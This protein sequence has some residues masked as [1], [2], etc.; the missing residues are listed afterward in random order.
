MDRNEGQSS[1][2]IWTILQGQHG[3]SFELLK[4]AWS[5]IVVVL[6]L[7]VAVVLF[8][9][10]PFNAGRWLSAPFPGFFTGP[11]LVITLVSQPE[12]NGDILGWQVTAVDG[13]ALSNS[14]DLT[15]ALQSHA[16][17]QSVQF[18]LRS[19]SGDLSTQ[20]VSLQT[21]PGMYRFTDLYFPYFVGLIYFLTALWIFILRG[22]SLSGQV[23]TLFASSVAIVTAGL[24]DVFTTQQWIYLWS[25]SLALASGT[26]LHFGLLFPRRSRLLARLPVL[27]VAPYL[28]AALL[29]PVAW[30]SLTAPASSTEFLRSWRAE[31]LFA[32]LSVLLFLALLFC[33]RSRS[34]SPVE[35]ERGLMVLLGALVSFGPVAF[36]FLAATFQPGTGYS[37]YL[38]LSLAI[39]PLITGYS[40]QRQRQLRTD[41]IISRTLL[42]AAMTVLAG[43]GYALLVS[44]LGIILIKSSLDSSA[45]IS[46]V[47]I[48]SLALLLNPLRLRAQNLVDAVFFRGEQALQDRIRTFGHALTN[49]VDLPEIVATLR[50]YIQ[51]ALIPTRLHVFI[52]DPL[53][54][55]YI[56]SLDEGGRASSEIRFSVQS[57]LIQALSQLQG[58]LFLGSRDDIPA[59]LYPD[60]PRLALLAAHV[61]LPLPGQKRLA[62]F[63]ALGGRQSGESYTSRDLTH[64]EALCDQAA[65]A[66]ERAQVVANMEHRVREMNVLSRVAQGV[67]VTLTFD[68]ILELIYAQTNQ[69]LPTR[70]FRLT[71]VD[72]V[73]G[74]FRHAFYLENDERLSE[75]ENHPLASNQT[76]EQEV[77]R[78]RKAILA[79]DCTHECQKRGIAA[80][81][82]GIFAWMGVP[83][84]AGAETIGALSLGSRDAAV[85][86]TLEQL[87]L[88][89]AIADQTAGA[90]VK[91][92]LLQESE[93]RALQL[94]TVNEVTRQLTS[95]LEL[96]PLLQ[97]ILQ[98][99]VYI[100]NSE[101][102]SLL[103]VDEQTDELVFR[104]AAGP[105]ASNLVGL[106][107]A[108]GSGVVGKSVKN[109]EPIIVNNV[110]N[111][112]DWFSKTDKQTGFS[113]QAL[114]VI[115]LEVKDNVI[116]VIEV[117]N[118]RDGL[119]F[120]NDDLATSPRLPARLRWPSKM[121]ACTP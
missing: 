14:A 109:R 113:T 97:N 108:P 99:A 2:P 95:T 85:T 101:A 43:A 66:I 29:S 102:G 15:R 92:R 62:G 17:G 67:N 53:S 25:F 5:Q 34:I 45:L 64:L 96:E 12:V 31:F 78:T 119:P 6:Y 36:W 105:V 65:L 50:R 77:A 49:T 115:P 61:F 106:R 11:H 94:S 22:R 111:T 56:A 30:F 68:D 84:N 87:N 19:P 104:V 44:G 121:H 80:S 18:S 103:L 72:P 107:M 7:M 20:E 75:Q 10:I 114:L 32:G 16:V 23:F 74:I 9:A 57:P 33:Q 38:V 42:Y 58:P 118:K 40:L 60:Q 13:A 86:Y 79:D 3:L 26:I 35:R 37:P 116:G 48:F 76:L 59:A 93:R 112:P 110:Q 83:L 70:D 52:Y 82:S 27:Q 71:L 69:L 8:V 100:L 88:L 47:I 39:F 90:I 41:Y 89:Q 63:L 54:D 117:I 1:S 98:N 28:I 91:A 21:F 81:F 4:T 46:G 24:F 51:E 73:T 120:T 55:Q